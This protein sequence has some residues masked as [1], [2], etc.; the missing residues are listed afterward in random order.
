LDTE[1][2]ALISSLGGIV[3]LWQNIGEQRLIEH[4]W[5]RDHL[6]KGKL[7]DIVF[8][9]LICSLSIASRMPGFCL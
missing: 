2:V 3:N 5:K 9:P 4:K 7:V 8:G 1:I 6:A